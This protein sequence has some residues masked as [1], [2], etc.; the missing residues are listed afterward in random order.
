MRIEPYNPLPTLRP[1][2]WFLEIAPGQ[3]SGTAVTLTTD[4]SDIAGI[5]SLSARLTIDPGAPTP[6]FSIGYNYNRLPVNLG[7]RAFYGVT[8][9]SGY[10]INDQN[11]T[12]NEHAAGITTGISLP[13]YDEF[14]R[15][16]LGLSYSVASYTADLPVVPNLDPY[17]KI[18]IRPRE[19][20]V[21]IVHLGY[22]F[23]NVEYG[24][25][26]PGATRGI[27][28]SM[29]LDYG[30]Q[31][32]ASN[33]STYAFEAT[34][35]GYIPMPW[36]WS[37]ARH[38]VLALRAA[39]GVS[40]GDY[41][42]GNTYYVGGYN[43][44]RHDL[45]DTI[46][47]GVFNGAFVLRGYAP[48]AFGGK[49][50]LLANAEYRFPIAVPDRGLST[51]PIYLKRI[52]GNLFTDVGGA[53]NDFNLRRAT[54]FKDDRF[55]DND[56]LHASLGAELWFGFVLGY[57]LNAQLRLGWARGFGPDSL[58]NGQWYFVASSAY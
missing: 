10:R 58:H 21:N 35:T 27:S 9:R 34:A 30:G 44:A 54:F 20:N 3:Y 15:H 29:T 38:H 22:G 40:G 32:T 46:T 31:A 2:N 1:Y 28:L 4:G 23:S 55:L 25:R 8:P 12:F 5:H 45:P 11:V 26:T 33:F 13:I 37:F 39:G 52:D 56:L 16:S 50:Y 7:I 48:S 14:A 6:D 17:S 42:G 49:E 19:G 47:S 36:P 18:T 53:F 51:L 41:P 57:G 43:L 24:L